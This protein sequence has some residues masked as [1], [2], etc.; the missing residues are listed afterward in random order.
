MKGC[1]HILFFLFLLFPS[2]SLRGQEK[3]SVAQ[4]S[5]P[6]FRPEVD[7]PLK[8][9]PFGA[10][11]FVVQSVDEKVHSARQSYIPNFRYHY[12]DYLQYAPMAMQV[13]MGA[14]GVKGRSQSRLHLLTA[15]AFA[16][17]VAASLVNGVKY[18]AQRLR[19]DG[20]AHNSFPSGH[21]ATAFLGAELFDLEYGERYPYLSAIA[22]TA[23]VTTGYSRVLN[24]KHWASD[25]F[26]GAGVGIL[27][28]HVGYWLSDLLFHGR[29]IK[30]YDVPD[31]EELKP[32][33]LTYGMGMGTLFTRQNNVYTTVRSSA[34][35][36]YHS[37]DADDEIL[38][39]IGVT[40]GFLT[41]SLNRSHPSWFLGVQTGRTYPLKKRW[42]CG[43]SGYWHFQNFWE[44]Y[45]EVSLF[46]EFGGRVFLDYYLHRHRS[47]RFFGSLGSG[48]AAIGD[49][50]EEG[51]RR[52]MPHYLL[53]E[54]GVTLQLHLF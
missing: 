16:T 26:A 36:T 52:L 39:S 13:S 18:S 23:A 3:E 48:W 40:A 4:D 15:D 44:D 47:I 20:S 35:V 14:L 41:H 45:P 34:E 28:A 8:A 30:Q 10:A 53:L 6:L 21:T 50:D 54:L 12:D 22:Y 9:L 38:T 37:Y 24:N 49:R 29:A 7:I 46:S 42:A 32:V 25:V 43:F 19:P 5:I 2:V 1:I 17:L 51:D 31:W 33:S 11:A 27:S